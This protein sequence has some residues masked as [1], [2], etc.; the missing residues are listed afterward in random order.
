[1][2]GRDFLVYF[3]VVAFMCSCAGKPE[4]PA[5][6][7]APVPV[8]KTAGSCE[9]SDYYV[10][11]EGDTIDMQV[12]RQESLK[13]SLKVDMQGNVSIPLVGTIKIAGLTIKEANDEITKR[14][15][16]YYVDPQVDLLI[17]ASKSQTVHVYGE[18]SNPGPI[19]LDHRTTAWEVIAK[20]AFTKNSEKAKVVL[21]RNAIPNGQPENVKVSALN[22]D[23][24]QL[25][26]GSVVAD[27]YVQSGDIIYVP[28]S[29]VSDIDR[30]MTHLGSI[31]APFL[32]VSTGIVILPQVIDIIKGESTSSG[33]SQQGIIVGH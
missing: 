19:T 28:P 3:T 2:T 33:S 31:I 4:P 27:C 26:H 10:L 6:V 23:P 21:I 16:K 17:S 13:R 30:L 18:V 9:P 12:W 24:T 15:G 11:G 32:G 7:E 1:V 5:R 8:V 20:A 29:R 25:Q 14:L 22:L